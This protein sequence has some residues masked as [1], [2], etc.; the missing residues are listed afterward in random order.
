MS[1]QVPLA[2]YF[3][4]VGDMSCL[5]CPAHEWDPP[6]LAQSFWPALAM[7][8][9]VLGGG[10]ADEAECERRR[11]GGRD[12]ETVAHGWTPRLSR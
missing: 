2:T 1:L 7:L 5:D 6:R 9:L 3:Q 12:D 11:E 8:A 4:S 10:L